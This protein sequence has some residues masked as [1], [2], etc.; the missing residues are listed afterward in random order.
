MK[1]ILLYIMLA[2]MVVGNTSFHQLSKLNF[3]VRH[4]QQHQERD[5]S[6]S[7]IGFL[8]MHYWGKDLPDHDDEQDNQLPFK[9]TTHH[10]H[11]DFFQPA[12]P[13]SFMPLVV[14]YR[15]V[16]GLP[17]HCDLPEAFPHALLRPPRLY[18]I[19]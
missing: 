13:A 2:V 9:R 6:L 8:R 3:L 5:H 19:V 12:A 10:F 15:S 18:T 7:F 16:Y 17:K 11:F 1:K 14:Y 4:F